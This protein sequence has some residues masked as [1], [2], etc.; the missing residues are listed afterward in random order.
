MMPPPADDTGMYI[1][2]FKQAQ[3]SYGNLGLEIE[4]YKHRLNEILRKYLGCPITTTE[5]GIFFKEVHTNDLYLATACAEGI[6]LAWQ[7]FDQC[8]RPYITQ[9]AKQE[10]QNDT[11]AAEIADGV[12]TDLFF[13]DKSNRPRIASYQGQA[14]LTRWLRMVVSYRA[15][16]ERKRKWNRFEPLDV[17]QH[18][19]D[20]SYFNRL[21]S[22]LR[23]KKYRPLIIG[24]FRTASQTLSPRERMILLMK[25]DELLAS[26]QIAEI[27]GVHASRVTQVLEL[28]RQKIQREVIA[29]LAEKHELSSEA[30]QECLIEVVNNPEYSLLELLKAS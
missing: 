29:I 5:A 10:Y 18:A 26:K 3:E 20:E 24:A 13:K 28:V 12:V 9:L 25:Y 22:Q 19:A 2:L 11:T 7:Q 6:E 17:V 15:A 16:D 1:E 14:S 4:V 23:T 30:I 27:L 21:S 8:F